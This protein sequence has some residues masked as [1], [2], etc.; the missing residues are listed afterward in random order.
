MKGDPKSTLTAKSLPGK[1]CNL[2][3]TEEAVRSETPHRHPNYPGKAAVGACKQPQ[4]QAV[5]S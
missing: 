1:L 3:A 4:D 5:G 2:L